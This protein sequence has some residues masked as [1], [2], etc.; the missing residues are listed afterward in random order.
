MTVRV[1]RKKRDPEQRSETPKLYERRYD[2]VLEKN[3]TR[4]DSLDPKFKGPYLILDIRGTNIKIRT[5][6]KERWI[7]ANRCKLHREFGDE[8]PD[9]EPVVNGNINTESQGEDTDAG[10][11]S[12]SETEN[13]DEPEGEGQPTSDSD[14]ALETARRYPLRDHKAKEYKDYVLGAKGP[15]V[16]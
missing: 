1:S 13:E 2:T 9:G 14:L 10:N 11:T 12:S 7:H 15:P 6:N 16:I 3:E 4:K 8:V 5:G